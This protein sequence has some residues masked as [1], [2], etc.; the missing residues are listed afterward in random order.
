MLSLCG[1]LLSVT[2]ILLADFLSKKQ[3]HYLSLSVVGAVFH[4]IGQ[5][6]AARF[7]VNVFLYYYIPVLIL[8][9]LLVGI[10]TGK[11]FTWIIPYL[12]ERYRGGCTAAEKS[13]GLLY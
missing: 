7:L 13:K 4:N 3:L 9:G 5:L 8:A 2:A 11:L 12:P 10:M 1:G 6:I